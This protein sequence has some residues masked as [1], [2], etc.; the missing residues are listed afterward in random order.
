MSGQA[1]PDRYE[2][3]RGQ[4]Q[5]VVV[6]VVARARHQAVGRFG[7][8]PTPGGVG[9]PAFGPGVTVVRLGGESLFVERAGEVAITPL[10][11][12]TLR[13]LA[14]AAG[15]DVDAELTV[16]HDTPPAVD[17]DETIDVDPA[18]LAAIG[19][20]LALGVAAIDE[21]VAGLGPVASPART[22]V[23]PE[24]F[25]AGTNVSVGPGPNDRVNLGASV[26]DGFHPEPYLYVGPWGADR[27]GDAAYWNAP[28]GA[29]LGWADVAAAADP[30]ATAVAFYREGLARFA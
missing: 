21:V 4:V 29:V 25:D 2:S 3:A 11:G 26:G 8:V 13:S 16:G 28:F 14:E 6:H 12:S 7:L 15:A 5:R 24:H 20:W 22:Q 23:W 10:A 9:T 19:W 18:A 1:L 30:V 17:V 27:P